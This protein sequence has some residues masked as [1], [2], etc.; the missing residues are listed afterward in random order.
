MHF[1][2]FGERTERLVT[3]GTR[4]HK[5]ERWKKTDCSKDIVVLLTLFKNCKLQKY[6][7]L[8]S[9]LKLPNF[10]YVKYTK[11]YNLNCVFQMEKDV[12]INFKY[13]V[14]L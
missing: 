8:L 13:G 14:D 9:F 11:A 6:L 1:C 7:N 12:D 4:K 3:L 10:L 5:V 2:R